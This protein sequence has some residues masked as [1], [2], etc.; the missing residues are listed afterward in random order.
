MLAF[1]TY[2]H[3]KNSAQ[4]ELIDPKARMVFIV[5][6][7]DKITEKLQKDMKNKTSKSDIMCKD[8][9]NSLNFNYKKLA[10][11]HKRTCNRTNFYDLM[12]EEKE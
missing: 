5:Q 1:I 7:Q 3:A 9:W 4:K 6:C 8:K 11:Y 2:K 10:Y 12:F